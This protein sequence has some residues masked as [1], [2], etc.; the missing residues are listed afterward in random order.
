MDE[1]DRRL[2][3]EIRAKVKELNHR[4]RDAVSQGIA[5][6]VEVT[7]FTVNMSCDPDLI[8]LNVK[9]FKSL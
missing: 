8:S 7:S 3:E 6:E 9:F 1:K 2:V 4:F 5:V